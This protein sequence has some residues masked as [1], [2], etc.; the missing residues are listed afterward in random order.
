[1]VT[2]LDTHFQ[3]GF[4]MGMEAIAKGDTIMALP[5]YRMPENEN[6]LGE[7]NKGVTTAYGIF[8]TAHAHGDT[9]S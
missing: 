9:S 4:L 7:F 1:M 6:A 8:K 5:W 2:K 3:R